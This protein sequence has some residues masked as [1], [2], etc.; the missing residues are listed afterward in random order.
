MFTLKLLAPVSACGVLPCYFQYKNLN[1]TFI[2]V[3]SI[4]MMC[5]L[6]L[7]RWQVL[8]TSMAAIWY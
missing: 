7:R 8:L 1:L 4:N 5:T 2:D 3:N 6:H